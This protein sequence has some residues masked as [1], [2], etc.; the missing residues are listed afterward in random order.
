MCGG[1]MGKKKVAKNIFW[2]FGGQIVIMLLGIIVPR[3]M[4]TGYGSDVNGL[5]STISQIFTYMALFEAGIG[6]AAKNALY[7]PIAEKDKDGIS[8]VAAVA[9]T[10]FRRV[11]IY[12]TI[13]VLV[14]ACALPFLLKSNVDK[15]TI[16]LIIILEGMSGVGTF[17]FVQ[18]QNTILMADGRGYIYN[19]INV[20]NRTLSYAVKIFM[21]SFGIHIVI[22]QLAYF[23]IT[24]GKVV[25]YKRYFH[26]KYGW[27]NYKLAPK[28][29]KLENR[30]AFIITEIAWTIF[31]STDMIILS[32]FVSTDMSSVYAVYNLVFSSLN[33]LLNAVYNSINYML[34]QTYYEDIEK[35]TKLH[36]TF[37]TIFIGTMTVLMS[38]SYLLILPFVRLYTSGVSDINYIYKSLPLMF[39]LVQ[40]LSWSRYVAGNLTILA[41]YAKR[42]SMISLLEALL[43]IS[44]SLILVGKWGITGVLAATVFALPIKVIWCTYI[45]DR[46]VLKRSFIKSISIIG[47]NYLIFAIT[48]AFNETVEVNV[49]SYREFFIIGIIAFLIIGVITCGLN[50]AVNPNCVAIAK[51]F[52]KRSKK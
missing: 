1:I 8:Y 48:V 10:Y 16:F 51:S 52:V 13:G 3:I 20:V 14:L 6:Q 17:Y 26:R 44:L 24:V 23:V 31:S 42:A 25:F 32:M 39:C 45:S 38:V 35:Y 34:G 15:M 29:A 27:I 5:M 4:L 7:K 21:A 50:I 47:I 18:T 22:L 41:G 11:T 19:G 2:G 37:N 36:D 40:M 43:N 12:Y 9:Q 49:G 33:T 46:R 30:N 28:T